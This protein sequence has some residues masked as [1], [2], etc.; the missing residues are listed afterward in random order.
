MELELSSHAFQLTGSLGYK[1]Q[2]ALRQLSPEEGHVNCQKM[3]RH[4]PTLYQP[5]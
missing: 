3:M 5:F 1:P 2:P 4:K